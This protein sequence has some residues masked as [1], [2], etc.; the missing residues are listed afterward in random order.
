MVMKQHILNGLQAQFDLYQRVLSTLTDEQLHTPLE[1]SHWT[2]KDV[3]GHLTS[4][5]TR[6]NARL[7]AAIE[8]RDPV[9]PIWPPDADPLLVDNDDQ[10]NAWLY[11]QAKDLPLSDVLKLWSS[12]FR[13]M[14]TLAD[15][16]NEYQVEW[17]C[18]RRAGQVRLPDAIYR[19]Y[20]H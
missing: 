6:S 7:E 5:L 16:L 13:E 18:T 14:I 9:Y 2:P 17:R 4:W 11:E 20:P 10:I 8:G 19:W 1:P 12:E 15:Q 3:V